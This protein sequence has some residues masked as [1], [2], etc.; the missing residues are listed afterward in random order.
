MIEVYYITLYIRKQ[1]DLYITIISIFCNIC[2]IQDLI[3]HK[4]NYMPESVCLPYTC[5]AVTTNDFSLCDNQRFM[6]MYCWIFLNIKGLDCML[7]ILISI[8]NIK[9]NGN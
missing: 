2:H 6:V 9:L 4:I 8:I 1:F 3:S 7:S 5:K